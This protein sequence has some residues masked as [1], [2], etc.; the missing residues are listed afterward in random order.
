MSKTILITGSNGLL[1][2]K[3]IHLLKEK[4]EV[5]ATSLGSCLISNQS[6]FI[7]QSLDITEEDSILQ[8]FEKYKPDFVINTAA[9]TNVDA[10]EDDKELCDKINVTAVNYLSTACEKFNS[11]LIHISTDFIFD[12]ENGPYREDDVANP[13]SYYGL[14]KWKS[15]QLLQQSNCKW[16]IL[17]TIIL[18]GTA[19]NLQR[20]NIVLWGRQALKDGQ[21]LNIIDDQ[22]RSPTLAEDLAEACRLVIEKQAIGVYNASGKDQMS[23]YEMVKRMADFYKCDKSQINRIS[24]ST[25][26]QKAKRPPK[27]GFILN[28]SIKELGY[29]PH[30]FEEGL[31]LLE[32]QLD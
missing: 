14:S 17:R 10:C 15:E 4:N 30:S 6:G 24:S 23:I 8:I 16:A 28:K 19:E 3:L 2:Q 13:L 22:F 32:K 21:E 5:V 9:M 7:Y 1:G 12:G 27:T 31:A 25:L 20:N 11:H 18:Y 29:K 26:N